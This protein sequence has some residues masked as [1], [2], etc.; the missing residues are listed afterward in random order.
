[1]GRYPDRT[2]APTVA[3]ISTAAET[4]NSTMNTPIIDAGNP[5][6]N[7]CRIAKKA[8]SVNISDSARQRGTALSL[9]QR[10]RQKPSGKLFFEKK[11]EM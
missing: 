4:A 10:K 3:V 11:S 6:P 2:N 9:T 8:I 7:M 5:K 1:M